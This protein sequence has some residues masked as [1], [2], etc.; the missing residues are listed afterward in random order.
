MTHLIYCLKY[1]QPADMR[2]FNTPRCD[3]IIWDGCIR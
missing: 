2:L 1:W 3:S